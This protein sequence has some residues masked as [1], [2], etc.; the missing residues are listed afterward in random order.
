VTR[1]EQFVE[2]GERGWRWVLDQVQH[3][4]RGP[5]I[6]ESFGSDEDAGLDMYVGIG[7]LAHTLAEIRLARP[8]T[9]EE[10]GLATGVADRIREATATRS[11][12]SYTGGL[13]SDI[14]ALEALDEPG[15]DAAFVRLVE[16]M[17]PDG[18]EQDWHSGLRP[19]A[20]VNDVIGGTAGTLL[21]ALWVGGDDARA[22]ARRAADVL[23]AEAEPVEDGLAW[24]LLPRR[25]WDEP[26]PL[27][28]NFSHGTAGIATALA[29][30]G[31]MLGRPELVD[32]AVLG[33]EF[34]TSIADTAHHGFEVPTRIP[35]N[36]DQEPFAY[37]WCHGPTG[38][39]YL[40]AALELVGVAQVAGEA[41]RD[42]HR[43]CLTS[44][45][46]SGLP[47]RVRPGFWDNDGRCCGTAGVGE[48][49]LDSW[50]RLGDDYDLAF[51]ETLGLAL[52]ERAVLDGDRGCWR[53][54]EHRNPDPLL[55]AGIGWMQGAA[56]I[57]AYLFRLGRLM[58][59]GRE[60]PAVRR[61][62]NW[63]A[64]AREL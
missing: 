60:A 25:W 11:G 22:A 55:P 48:A 59:D 13:A 51:A 15:S 8:W 12:A 30:A 39:S 61:M 4:D 2:L 54:V 10:A 50:Q 62:D 21:A 33:A 5:W 47:M 44:V 16:L 32:A 31:P 29:L 56:G 63:W 53:F 64:V 42:W 28:P 26:W 18:W 43:R 58:A 24:Q 6:A 49:F 7:G 23:L 9:E 41:P 19:G 46:N 34:L 1:A 40:F 27:M 17:R 57:S 45:V 38:T 37:G 52:Q 36:P 14:G 20:T 35:A 3:D